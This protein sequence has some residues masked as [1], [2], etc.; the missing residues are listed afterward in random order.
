MTAV[1]ALPDVVSATDPLAS[2]QPAYVSK[3]GTVVNAPISFSGVPASLDESY[4]DSLDAAVQPVWAAGLD[5]EYGGGAGQ[6]GKAIVV[7]VTILAALTPIPAL[8][9]LA[10]PAGPEPQGPAASR[11]GAVCASGS[12]CSRSTSGSWMPVPTRTPTRAGRRTT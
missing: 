2:S 4:L 1:A 6:I 7:A 9:G 5:V 10:K 8:L 12:P 11:R 3:D